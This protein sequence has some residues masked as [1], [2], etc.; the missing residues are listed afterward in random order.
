MSLVSLPNSLSVAFEPRTGARDGLM[1]LADF[2]HHPIV[3]RI[4]TRFI[5]PIME[6]SRRARRVGPVDGGTLV[7]LAASHEKAGCSTMALCCAAAAAA[8]EP[9]AL[10]D[11]DLSSRGLTQLLVGRPAVGWD[12]VVSGASS[13]QQAVH[14]VDA[15]EAL[16]FFPIRA[17]AANSPALHGQPGLT[18]WLARLRGDYP[19]VFLDG[20]SIESGAARWAPWVDAALIVCD[21][22]RSVDSEWTRVWDRLEEGGTHVLGIVETF[23]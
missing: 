5:Q 10:V 4:L 13:P 17:A 22:A 1:P 19:L 16:A 15:R 9:T 6:L 21:A 20:G 7:L 23:V 12:D 3:H 11:A 2:S 18:G 8:L 14:Y